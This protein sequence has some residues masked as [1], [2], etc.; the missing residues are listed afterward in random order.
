MSTIKGKLLKE[1]L[2]NS[3]VVI[4]VAE[5]F[6]H[7]SADGAR[8]TKQAAMEMVAGVCYYCEPDNPTGGKLHHR[9]AYC[10]FRQARAAT[11]SPQEGDPNSST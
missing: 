8:I 4:K 11:A 7:Y 5:I 10:N 1:N 9:G 3:P 2:K 6:R